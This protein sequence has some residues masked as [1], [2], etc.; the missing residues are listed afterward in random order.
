MGGAR[1]AASW[2]LRKALGLPRAP[3]PFGVRAARAA[4]LCAAFAASAAL[5]AAAGKPVVVGVELDNPPLEYV[6]AAG[7]PAGYGVDVARAAAAAMKMDV[8]FRLGTW[9]DL[10]ERLREG[11]IDALAGMYDSPERRGEVEF[12]LPYAVMTYGVFVRK[13]A[14]EVAGVPDL[15]G[16]RVLVGRSEIME[17]QLRASGVP[18]TLEA[19]ASASE[20]LSLLAGGK[21]DAAAAPLL[22]GR[23]LERKYHL[24]N[25][26]PSGPPVRSF[27]L[28]FAVRK[29]N[30]EL[31]ARLDEGL[32]LIREDGGLRRI[33]VRWFGVVEEEAGLSWAKAIRAALVA[34]VPLLAL[35]GAAGLWSWSLRR[36][37]RRK[38]DD[39]SRELEQRRRTE[40]LLE[41][42]L[43]AEN[44]ATEISARFVGGRV[45]GI[46]ESIV[47]SLRDLA[48]HFGAD[49]GRLLVA[50]AAGTLRT[51]AV[52]RREPSSW[53]PL[54]PAFAP[55]EMPWAFGRLRR[56]EIVHF[57]REEDF[58]PEAAA[59]RRSWT[60]GGRPS[61]V[62]A[63]LV[64]DGG[65][66]G[67]VE[68]LS[69]GAAIELDDVGVWL[70][71]LCTEVLASA[72]DR[73]VA[74]E[75]LA[76]EKER[77]SVTLRSI[78]EGVL[79]AD[80]E[81][82]V[83]L[84]N[85]AAERITGWRQEEAAGRPLSEILPGGAAEPSAATSDARFVGRDGAERVV[86]RSTAPIVDP[87]GGEVGRVVV[88][89][90]VTLRRR[91]E[92][93]LQRTAKLEAL[94]VLA[95][96]I[97]HDFNNILTG[98]LGSIS[99]ARMM[100][101]SGTPEEEILQEAEKAGTRAVG[102]ARQLLT[103]SKGGAP[104]RV[105]ARIAEIVADSVGFA[106]RGSRTRCV[107]ELPPNL[108]AGRVDAVQFSQV[109]QNLVINAAQAMPEGGTVTISARN[110][111][112][113]G[114]GDWPLPAGRYVETTVADEGPGIPPET[115][116]RIFDPFFT[117][118]A[119]G[120]GLGLTT[121]HSIMAR[122]GGHVAVASTVG[123]GTTFTLLLPA[124]DEAPPAER[125]PAAVGSGPRGRL[126][127]MDDEELVRG[128]AK[129]LFGAFGFSVETA[130][131]GAEAVATFR[132][133]AEERRPF[134]LV[135]LDLTVPGR[136]GG[137]E[138]LRRL[139][140]LSSDLRA[141]VSSGYSDDPVMADF[142]GRGFDGVLP[143]PYRAEDVEAMLAT[144]GGRP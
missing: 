1:A 45:S 88:L 50:D 136:M 104:I 16:K 118:K 119:T 66:S 74:A 30:R 90:D 21:G 35:L 25:I 144:L 82:R 58:P 143:K 87:A 59:E 83:V 27:D 97:A 78:G 57:G 62:A 20:A 32:N 71:R 28:C 51:D 111:E 127:L 2:I 44:L 125:A 55:S 128:A 86:E 137:E 141:V 33:H 120:S 108:W 26:R 79:A 94:G 107:L 40:A 93:D 80:A 46:A 23:Y 37:V 60:E 65:I 95:G 98:I 42:R 124:T 76:A 114:R 34:F 75:R 11:E 31:R 135:V 102:L 134:E 14:P 81:G 92:N 129:A 105:A 132:R 8:A 3:A 22:Y 110:V 77:L 112:Y 126:L 138:C 52:W 89:R 103:L 63:P 85:P 121:A 56:G 47:L 39:L 18:L 43:A 130:A 4:A 19:A 72:H 101:P 61:V 123:R 106:L 36:Q 12:S 84:L 9:S 53:T 109:V 142:R 48:R 68:L 29:G 69:R 54:G 13:G 122:H 5:C 49:G 115:L 133:A 131:D 24:E 17:E 91:M 15:A 64:R 7:R 67:C 70:L 117:T 10:R 38:T 41:R 116:S 6:D 139:R 113:D 73:R 96:G 140:E 100:L 99:V